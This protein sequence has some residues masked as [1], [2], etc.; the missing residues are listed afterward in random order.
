MNPNQT[1]GTGS[2]SQREVGTEPR[3]E[4]AYTSRIRELSNEA[5][6]HAQRLDRILQNLRG[7]PPPAPASN[8]SGSVRQSCIEDHIGMAESS[9]KQLA[10][11]LSE[12]ERLIG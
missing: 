6:R 2:A 11:M 3:P 10:D 12:V 5:E 9:N 8:G 4:S 7:Y 1:Y